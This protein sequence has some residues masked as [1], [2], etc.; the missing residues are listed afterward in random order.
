MNKLLLE[1]HGGSDENYRW[2]GW[3]TTNRIK[4][5][6]IKWYLFLSVFSHALLKFSYF[7]GAYELICKY[8]R[9]QLRTRPKVE[10]WYPTHDT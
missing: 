6:L 9:T 1:N 2:H 3:K 5:P 7:H 8:H 4:M 10:R